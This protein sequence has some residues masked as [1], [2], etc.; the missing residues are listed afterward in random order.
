MGLMTCLDCGKQISQDALAC[1]GCGRPIKR[2]TANDT[3]SATGVAVNSPVPTVPPTNIGFDASSGVPSTM[4]KK[5]DWS[6]KI[7]GLAFLLALIIH[8]FI[9]VASGVEPPKKPMHF[10]W[11]MMWMYLSIDAWKYWKWKALLPYPIFVLVSVAIVLIMFG[12]NL[13][14]MVWTYIVIQG[15]LNIGGLIVFY[16]ELQ[17][18]KARSPQV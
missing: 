16:V 6:W 1:I 12:D 5:K 9:G 18:T 15:T 7:F 17:K 4:P 10:W 13:E 2:Y 8:I 14:E 3:S 11:T